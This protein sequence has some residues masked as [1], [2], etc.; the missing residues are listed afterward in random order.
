MPARKKSAVTNGKSSGKT[1]VK[2]RTK[3]P[4]ANKASAGKL[5]VAPP[6]TERRKA[7]RRPYQS[8]LGLDVQTLE[9]TYKLLQPNLQ[10][11]VQ[12]FY[13]RLFARYPNV[14]PLF[15]GTTQAAQEKKL[16]TALNVVVK[17]LRKPET[18]VNT[19]LTLGERHKVYGAMP[20]HYAAVASVLLDV[21]KDFTG[22]VWTPKVQDAWGTALET[23]AATMLK[24]HGS[25]AH[26]TTEEMDMATSKKAVEESIRG[27]LSVV[28]D[29]RMMQ[30]ILEHAPVNVMIADAEHN[31]VFVNKRARDVFEQLESELATYLPNFNAS[32]IV[33]GSIHRYHKDANAIKNI[34]AGLGPNGVHKGEIT[35]GR[36]IFEH[37]TRG[38]YDAA[39]TLKG[40]VVQWQ[41]VTDK[42]RNEEQAQRLQAAVDGAQTAMMMID[43]DLV[44]N[45]VNE[46]TKHLLRNNEATLKSLFPGFSAD[47]IVGT[48]I[49]IFH[50]NPDHQ[51]RLLADPRNLPYETDIT[52]GPMIFHIRASAIYD[53]Q[54]NYVGTTLEW[55]DVTELRKSEREVARLKSAV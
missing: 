2:K 28:D 46:T 41:D 8:P 27:S 38:L 54:S 12:S 26:E 44:V 43:R 6:P 53:L 52:V 14:K 32:S 25:N 7:T 18:L 9:Q 16:L 24:A 13:D 48:C 42:R 36:F 22:D 10:D 50:K 55:S 29:L 21:F 47:K 35:P 4:T 19:L 23:I 3:K 45:Y 15:S 51:R 31:I 17:N 1:T 11:V 34:L 30:D 49:D 40:Y 37:E 5:A 33:G 39:G 20:E